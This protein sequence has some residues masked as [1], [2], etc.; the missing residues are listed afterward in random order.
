MRGGAAL[1]VSVVAL[2]L[3]A[4]LV[5]ATSA[6]AAP[7]RLD[8][9]FYDPTANQN[10]GGVHYSTVRA[11]VA[12][13]KVA[14]TRSRFVRIPVRW[15]RIACLDVRTRC[16]AMDRP[17]DPSD[18][19][20]PA[21][22]WDQP[23]WYELTAEI[24][25]ARNNGLLPVLSVFGAPAYAECDGTGARPGTNGILKCPGRPDR[26]DEGNF[27][28]DPQEY[29]LFLQAVS[30][31]YP[32]V[33]HF[34]VWNEPNYSV[35]LK[36]ART[37]WTVNRYRALV[38]RASNAL[39]SK[40]II[41]GGTAPNARNYT[42][43]KAYSPKE[44]MKRLLARKVK[45]DAYATH[46]YTPG[47]PWTAAANR[48]GSVWMGNLGQI[49]GV[50]RRAERAGRIQSP[51]AVQLWVTEMSWDSAPPDC[52]RGVRG[53]AVPMG[54]LTRWVAESAYSIWRQG[55]QV[56]IWGQ[57]KDYPA[58][59]NPHQG[60]LYRGAP[61]DRVGPAKA[62]MRPFRFPFVAY[63][64][65]GGA[66]VWG[67][68]PS[69]RSGW[70]VVQ[71]RVGGAW[72]KIAE[73]KTNDHGLFGKRLHFNRRKVSSLRARVRAGA[74]SAPFALNAP[75]VPAGIVPFGCLTL[76]DWVR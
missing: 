76:D 30:A 10:G 48:T 60:G 44:F 65:D 55:F 27:R 18:P 56:M 7:S 19:D 59:Q 23:G 70:V 58:A 63:K 46:P 41:A 16:T 22:H 39:P 32:G 20:S 21:Y 52:R 45:F 11:D 17:S 71:R 47:G 64:R 2:A 5:A 9:G 42:H 6:A 75:R 66:Y 38:N 8:M 14:K 69:S 25:E 4:A 37:R 24:H 35:F 54:L 57:L 62:A 43:I 12:M 3:A 31:K 33:H 72:D 15:D 1:Q 68:L 74:Y 13:A 53:R 50:I 73:F 67:R 61:K 40:F 49:R 29:K 26:A 36:P 28:P 34:Q 51:R